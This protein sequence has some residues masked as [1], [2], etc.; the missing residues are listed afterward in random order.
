MPE[1]NKEN[2]SAS[3]PA[4][5]DIPAVKVATAWFKR[6]NPKLL[7][8]VICVLFL[9]IG[10]SIFNGISQPKQQDSKVYRVG[11]LSGLDFFAGTVDGFKEGMKTLGYEEGRNIVYVVEK[12][13]TPVG[14]E[15]VIQKFVN[16]KVDLILTFPTEPSLEA[17][18]ITAGTDIPVVFTNA[19][20]DGVNLVDSVQKP[21]GNITGV[22]FPTADN[23]VNRL[24]ILHEL[25]PQAKT[26]WIAYL[27]GYP[28]VPEE[29]KRLHPAAKSLGLTLIEAPVTSFDDIKADLEK[30]EKAG[31]IGFDAIL[32]IPEPITTAP[33]IY[34][35]ISNFAIKHKKPL[36]GAIFPYG[37]EGSIFGYAP[38]SSEV[39]KQ[40]A[41]LADK[42]FK[43]TPAGT[44]P[45][46]SSENYLIINYKVAQTFG[47]NVSEALLSRAKQIIR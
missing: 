39:G 14:N 2:P 18:K 16:D 20:L 15:T 33:D 41:V 42:I 6:I 31:N 47:L 12:T 3:I 38:D 5:S 10:I 34:T 8:A 7:I 36:G 28:I 17:K 37:V 26:I 27:K 40:A 45:V 46:V 25:A 29:L 30:R 22:Q 19:G 9:V 23:A 24:E 13:P 44:I 1:E 21:G 11:I 32:I 35:Y 4:A 43:G